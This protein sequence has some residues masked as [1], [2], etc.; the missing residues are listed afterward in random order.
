[1]LRHDSIGCEGDPFPCYQSHHCARQALSQS[2]LYMTFVTLA[3]VFIVHN[4][5]S[6][7]T[8]SDKD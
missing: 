7:T 2:G 6:C 8:Q 1:M 3:Q 5:C 4:S